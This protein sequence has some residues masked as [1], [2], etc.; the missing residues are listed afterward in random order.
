M[1]FNTTERLR[2]YEKIIEGEQGSEVMSLIASLNYH[3][4]SELK[5]LASPEVTN[6]THEVF[7]VLNGLNFGSIQVKGQIY[8]QLFLSDAVR[9]EFGRFFRSTNN[10]LTLDR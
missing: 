4:N 2:I 6:L 5:D 1:K 8:D 3:N 10:R 9:T 7:H